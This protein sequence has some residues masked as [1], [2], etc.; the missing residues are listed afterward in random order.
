MLQYKESLIGDHLLLVGGNHEGSN[1]TRCIA[2][3]FLIPRVRRD[4]D[5]KTQPC[6]SVA[7]SGTN[8]RLVLADARCK[9]DGIK[10]PERRR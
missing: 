7:Y 8:L 1:A 4:I 5:F 2:D 9:Y 10:T 6:Q 3:L